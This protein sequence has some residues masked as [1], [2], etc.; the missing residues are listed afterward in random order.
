MEIISVHKKQSTGMEVIIMHITIIA[1]QTDADEVHCKFVGAEL[2]PNRCHHDR[3][4]FTLAGYQAFMRVMDSAQ[5]TQG[6][7]TYQSFFSYSLIEQ[8]FNQW[9]KEDSK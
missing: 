6:K 7:G 3:L 5:G 9:V 1:T 2:T 4:C 8:D